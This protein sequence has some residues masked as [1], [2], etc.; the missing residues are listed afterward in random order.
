MH[1]IYI[2]IYIYIERERERERKMESGD[3][4]RKAQGKF[5]DL[6][7]IRMTTF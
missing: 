4:E 5:I 7:K 3:N 1:F 2:Y 6:F